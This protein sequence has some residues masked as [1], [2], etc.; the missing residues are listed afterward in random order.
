MKNKKITSLLVAGALTVGI[1]GGT[2]AW[3]TASDSVTNKFKTGENQS[4]ALDIY[5]KFD[6]DDAKVLQPGKTVDKKV[7]VKNSATFDQFIRVKI[8][9][10]TTLSENVTMSFANTTGD[11]PSWVKDGDYYYYMGKV[12]AGKY[13]DQLLDK[14]TFSKDANMDQ[15]NKAFNIKVDAESV[16][17]SNGAYAE[18][19]ADASEAIKAKLKAFEG[20]TAVGNVNPIDGATITANTE[21]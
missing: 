21:Y 17:A 6:K 9:L 20:A 5:E 10:D 12:A 14:V 16:Q 13:T 1:V 2:L 19:F 15:M 8:T 3:L 18:K 4:V 11:N 7:Q